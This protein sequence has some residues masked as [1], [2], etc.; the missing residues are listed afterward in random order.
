MWKNSAHKQIPKFQL[1]KGRIGL[2]YIL[3]AF[4]KGLRKIYSHFSTLSSVF[5]FWIFYT[6]GENRPFQLQGPQQNLFDIPFTEVF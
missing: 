6:S 5:Q 4:H 3:H 2:M 1:F